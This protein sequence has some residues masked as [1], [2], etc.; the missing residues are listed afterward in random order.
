LALHGNEL[1][2]DAGGGLGELA[3]ALVA[4]YPALRV[5]LLD[6]PEVVEQAMSSSCLPDRVEACAANLFEPWGFAAD[7][8]V[9][10]RVLHDWNDK[11][12]LQ[13]LHHAR[14]ALS[15]GGRLFI[16]EMVI[17]EDSHAGSLCD[18]HLLMATGGRERTVREYVHLMEQS[19]FSFS[20]VRQLPALP[21]V[22]VGVAR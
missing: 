18:L 9:L 15:S 12:A 5:I 19:G 10:A 20:E 1:I 4:Y 21:S 8:V 22:V 17:S 16:V 14:A 2:V 3:A 6:R 7:S 11:D 13:I